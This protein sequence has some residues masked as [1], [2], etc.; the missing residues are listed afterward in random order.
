M[1]ATAPTILLTLLLVAACSSTA[2]TE[3]EILAGTAD[4]AKAIGDGAEFVFWEV[5]K[6]ILWTVPKAVLYDWP[7]GVAH[8]FRDTRGKVAALVA[9]LEENDLSTEEQ[10]ARS[11]ELQSLTGLPIH[12]SE[13]WVDW[14]HEEGEAPVHQWR[15]NYVTDAIRRLESDDY[16]SRATAIEDLR[17]MYGTDLGY[18]PK[19]LPAGREEGAAKWKAYFRKKGMPPRD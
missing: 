4:T 1:R 18:D 7:R 5:P 6:F 12:S 9:S 19:A 15:E 3:E 10:I 17:L 11:E 13:R 2:T 8:S 16:F 14:W